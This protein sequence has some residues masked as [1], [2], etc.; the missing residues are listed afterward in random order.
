MKLITAAAAA[1]NA[2][3]LQSYNMF[4]SREAFLFAVAVIG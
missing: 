4:F 3:S 1:L 2:F